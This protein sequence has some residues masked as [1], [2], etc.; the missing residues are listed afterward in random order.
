MNIINKL[1]YR[2]VMP[3]VWLLAGM[4]VGWLAMGQARIE[5]RL[6]ALEKHEH[7][8]VIEGASYRDKGNPFPEGRYGLT[9]KNNKITLVTNW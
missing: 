7:P 4:V 6:D 9:L 1:K 3:F 2:H 5:Q 8:V